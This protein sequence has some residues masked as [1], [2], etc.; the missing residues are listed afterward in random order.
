VYNIPN[1]VTGQK[2]KGQF[3]FGSNR[4]LEITRN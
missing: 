3:G 2:A 4:I 1:V